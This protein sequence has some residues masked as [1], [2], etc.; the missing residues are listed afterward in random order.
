MRARAAQ[1]CAALG[2]CSTDRRP[3]GWRW[4][5]PRRW[6][7]PTPSGPRTMMT[8][9]AACTSRS[10]EASSALVASSSSRICGAARWVGRRGEGWQA[11]GGRERRRGQAGPAEAQVAQVPA[12]AST[13]PPPLPLLPTLGLRTMARAMAMRCFWPP[14]HHVRGGGVHQVRAVRGCGVPQVQGAAAQQAGAGY[15]GG[16]RLSARVQ[17]R[18]AAAFER[19]S[20]SCRPSWQDACFT[21]TSAAR[22]ARPQRCRSRRAGRR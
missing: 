13:T 5:T 14:L 7:T 12:R 10:E 21:R 8:S 17:S 4:P 2:L 6:R 9:S 15:A 22:P 19:R 11:S 3:G 1:P 20:L 18:A 16:D